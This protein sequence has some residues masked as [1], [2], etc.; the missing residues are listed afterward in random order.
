MTWR[1]R[2]AVHAALA[3]P[4]RLLIT[5]ALDG[6]R[7]VPLRARG[8]AGDAVQPARPPPGRAG[9]GRAW[10][11]AAARRATAGVPTC[12]WYRARS[13]RSPGRRR[14][15][16][17]GCCS[18]AP[19]TRP[20]R[21][22]RRRCGAGPARSPRPRPAPARRPR[23]TPARSPPPGA[24]TCRCAACARGTSTTS[25]GRGPRGHGVRPGPR[26]TRRA[27][28]GA[29]VGPRPGR[30]PETRA[31]STRPWPTWAS[32]SGAS[33]RASR[34]LPARRRPSG[35]ERDPSLRAELADAVRGEPDGQESAGTV[36]MKAL[37][38][39]G[40]PAG[41]ATQTGQRL[42][43]RGQI[44]GGGRRRRRRALRPR[45]RRRRG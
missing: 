32:A 19:P 44:R 23:S 40:Q 22:W 39:C 26:G 15:R 8:A 5:D 29:L 36:R 43:R 45:R 42:A 34:P 37:D 10:S 33:R 17:G 24:I 20:A 35:G 4:A 41:P 9:A 6:G 12:G 38:L 31:A 30:R 18:C 11:A 1:G 16:R 28:G 13:T 3:D 27:G 21:T 25:P 7:R 14:G 2:A